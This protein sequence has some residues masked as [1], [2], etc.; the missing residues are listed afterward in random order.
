MAD[1]TV[2][3]T[4]TGVRLRARRGG[5]AA[6]LDVEAVLGGAAGRNYKV[7]AGVIRNAG[8][9]SG[10]W[11]PIDDAGHRPTL[12]DSVSTSTSSIVINHASIAAG[13][14][15]ALVAVPDETLTAAGFTVGA[16]VGLDTTTLFLS[17]Q[18]R[19][20]ADYVS[21]SGTAWSS[22]AGIFTPTWDATAQALVLTHPAVPTSSAFAASLAPRGGT[23]VTSV[24]GG[25][26]AV[27]ETHV[28][29]EFWD[30]AGVKATT[31]NA[32]MRLFVT[33][34]G[35]TETAVNPQMVDT[36]AFPNSNIWFLGVFETP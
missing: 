34:G 21:Y 4:T 11:Q 31:P 25:S 13:K 16:S 20:L 27:S 1:L 19:I 32:N 15:V 8:S 7:V 2:D 22:S 18:G 23:Y 36:T 5:A 12:I 29:V 10:Y 6:S 3:Q 24:K 30:Y 33:R 9:G 26:N 28:A 17:R 35:H 14:V